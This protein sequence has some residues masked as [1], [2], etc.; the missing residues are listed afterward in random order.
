MKRII[1]AALFLAIIEFGAGQTTVGR[2]LF[3]I[4]LE[5]GKQMPVLILEISD[6]G[7]NPTARIVS[8]TA[9][10]L[11][12]QLK[13]IEAGKETLSLE[14]SSQRGDLAFAAQLETAN[15][16]RGKVNGGNFKDG[17][18]IA[19]RTLLE[20]LDR[21]K[22]PS[23]EEQ[24]E[25]SRAKALADPRQR[26]KALLAFIT[27]HSQSD[28]K[29]RAYNE[30]FRAHILLR[31]PD[32]L[33][34]PAA[35][36][37]V[38]SARDRTRTL[39]SMASAL[40]RTNRL[41]DQAQKYADAAVREAP[42]RSP[43]QADCLR[44]RALV[45]FRK[46]ELEA[47]TSFLERSI[48]V[49]PDDGETFALLAEI[50]QA[51]GD[52]EKARDAYLVSYLN[53]GS[54]RARARL[55]NFYRKSKGSLVGLHELIDEEYAKRPSPFEAGHYSGPE[56]QR[57][58]LVELFTGSECGP[59]QASDLAFDGLLEHYPNSAIA[60]IQYHLHIPKPDPMTNQDSVERA[61]YYG[62]S[63]TPVVHVSGTSRRVGGSR[64]SLAPQFF[65]DYKTL[66]EKHLS[67]PG[68]AEIDVR[69]SLKGDRIEYQVSGFAPS[70]SPGS[71]RLRLAL[72]EKEVHYTGYNGIH[73]HRNTVR[74]MLG[75]HQGIPMTPGEESGVTGTQS[76]SDLEAELL[77]YLEGYQSEKGTRFNEMPVTIDSS[78]LAL[79]AWV[80][81]DDDHQVLQ[82]AFHP[83]LSEAGR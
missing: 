6:A 23:R 81:D 10:E 15:L 60:A 34:R 55:E 75:G 53:T 80:Q 22:P 43:Q 24:R 12:F 77:D 67:K 36:A 20:T 31:S 5:D 44:T 50:W 74:K 4:L 26:I 68:G 72:V 46:G 18:F 49:D 35:E 3:S 2:W 83:I 69:G 41:L 73:Y 14:L 25:Y 9:P 28:L 63:S 19:E 29:E 71:L 66:I 45:A 70:G 37:V 1:T 16:L 82:S 58:V 42:P 11:Q 59:C 17:D 21:P 57:V 78:R 47:A 38:S 27:A 51:R 39:N 54:P 52:E 32:R 48:S 76:L 8:S 62:V 65:A 7:P 13:K 40:A 61:K 30:I 56:P 79:V 64:K 33:L